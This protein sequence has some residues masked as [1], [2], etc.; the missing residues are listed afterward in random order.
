MQ[1]LTKARL[2][3]DF[4]VFSFKKQSIQTKAFYCCYFCF[5]DDFF[6]S[7]VSSCFAK[8]M[9]LLRSSY[10]VQNINKFCTST[11]FFR[12]T[13]MTMTETIPNHELERQYTEGSLQEKP[14]IIEAE[15]DLV[16]PEFRL[17]LTTKT[18]VGLPLPAVLVQNGIKVACEA[19]ENFRDSVRTNFHVVSG[20][21]NNCTPV[22]GTAAESSFYKVNKTFFFRSLVVFSIFSY[23]LASFSSTFFFFFSSSCPPV[24]FFSPPSP[25]SCPFFFAT[26]FSH[27]ASPPVFHPVSHP[28]SFRTFL[29]L[30][31]LFPHPFSFL[32]WITVDHRGLSLYQIY[33]IGGASVISCS[34]GPL[35]GICALPLLKTC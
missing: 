10:T 33:E 5:V 2:S 4:H 20:S 31:Y 27:S 11:I 8:A 23:S 32:Y 19:K 7:K 6:S 25:F 14:E 15:D 1:T 24:I 21:L 9:I 16:H 22:W 34:D 29:P 30:Q 17:W 3:L 18:N 35:P 28:S 13:I 26:F 12:Q